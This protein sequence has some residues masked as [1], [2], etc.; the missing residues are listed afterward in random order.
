MK[1]FILVASVLLA[2]SAGC[3]RMQPAGSA[4]QDGFTVTLAAQPA[5]PVVGE[6]T[7]VVSL[8]D[9]AGQPVTGARLQVEGNMN[10]AGMK[11]SFGTVR[12]AEGGQYTVV[13]PWTMAGDWYVDVKATL[14]DGR[15]IARRFPIAVHV[16]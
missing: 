15:S 11:P 8:R 12:A 14:A 16:R 4:P 9:P 6:G 2:L 13:I 1:R 10:H 5:T 7:L 3:G